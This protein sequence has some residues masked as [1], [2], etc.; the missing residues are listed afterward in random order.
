MDLLTEVFRAYFDARKHK[1][2]TNNQLK[3]EMDME[4]HLIV[5]AREIRDRTYEVSPG[6]GFIVT[7]PVRR[8]IFAAGF[9]DRV[10]HHLLYNRIEAIAE[11]TFI[12]DC[13]SCRK[14][15]GT[16]FGVKRLKRHIRSCSGNYTRKAY[17]LKMD[18]QGYFMSIDRGLL[19]R[20]MEDMLRKYA[21]RKNEKGVRWKDAMDVEQTLY[22]LEKVIFND[23]TVGCRLKSKREEWELLPPS[24]SLFHSPP[25][26][27]L[28][29]GNLT[30]QLFSN[31][32]LTEF[33]HYVKRTLGMQHY[34]RYVD[35]FYIV[36]E[37]RALLK[38]LPPVIARY[39]KEELGLTLHPKKITLC[40]AEKG[41]DFLGIHVMPYRDYVVTRTKRSI[42]REM[43]RLDDELGKKGKLNLQEQAAVRASVN[44]YF[45]YLRMCSTFL[46]RKKLA[47]AC[48]N[49]SG[50]GRFTPAYEKL[51]L[52][53]L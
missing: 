6:V 11:R 21:G 47:N 35:D 46:L 13:Y 44:S 14:G 27:G 5:L 23:P 48:R 2:N 10:V 36:H 12:T 33:D 19:Y 17:I 7:K 45:G 32:Y 20:K 8:E 38:Q 25:G 49:V 16:S 28:P 31:I 43:R 4:H 3:F 52:K 42:N 34:G 18:I 29:I 50:A 37:N 22:L 9:R 1:R 30:S 26:C 41:V 51:K 24:K 39:L 40:D 53:Q 15:Y